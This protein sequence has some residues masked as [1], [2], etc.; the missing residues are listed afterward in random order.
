VQSTGCLILSGTT[1]NKVSL[2][3]GS[4]SVMVVKTTF[5]EPEAFLERDEELNTKYMES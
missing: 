2:A 5:P 3:S 4:S 1:G